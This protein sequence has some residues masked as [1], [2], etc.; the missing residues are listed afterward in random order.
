MMSL[1]SESAQQESAVRALFDRT[2]DYVGLQRRLADLMPRRDLKDY[3]GRV[4][5]TRKRLWVAG[6]S[7][8][9]KP[10]SFGSRRPPSVQTA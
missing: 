3:Q 5:A 1:A 8:I 6:A 2:E 9:R 10:D 4:W 7:L